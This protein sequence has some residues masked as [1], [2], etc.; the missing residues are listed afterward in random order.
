MILYVGRESLERLDVN[1]AV[2][3]GVEARRFGD[4]DAV[5]FR[6]CVKGR[7]LAYRQR[8]TKI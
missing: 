8:N 5:C 4:F 1:F 6:P 7:A 2:T 3:F